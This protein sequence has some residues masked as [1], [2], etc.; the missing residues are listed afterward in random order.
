M[1]EQYVKDTYNKISENFSH[2]RYKIWH[3]T[4]IFLDKLP[5]NSS[6]LEVGCGNGKNMMYRQD[7]NFT[8]IDN[9]EK[10][11]EI[12]R[13]KNLNVS[14]HCMTNL[15]FENKSFDYTICIASLHH[16]ETFERR[17]TALNEMIRVTKK[18]ILITL[19]NSVSKSIQP[20]KN[21]PINLEN[22][23]YLVPWKYRG[24]TY[25]R[26]YH[27]T[28]IEELEKLFNGLNYTYYEVYGNY[29]IEIK[30]D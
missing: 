23:N 16:L 7:L 13:N 18:K 11:V 22:N 2:T 19:W 29:I 9:S 27:L 6:V 1:E 25:Y 21:K 4:E 14:L 10:L 15:P 8:G 26:F 3:D 5:S 30:C 12:C 24:L 28:T 17:R 20:T